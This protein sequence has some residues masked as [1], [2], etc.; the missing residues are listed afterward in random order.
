MLCTLSAAGGRRL[1]RLRPPTFCSFAQIASSFPIHIFS[2]PLS[3]NPLKKYSPPQLQSSWSRPPPAQQTSRPQ[4]Q[5]RRPTNTYS[6]LQSSLPVCASS[7]GN[8]S[9]PLP[10]IL[11]ALH[12]SL[13]ALHQSSTSPPQSY[14]Q[15][16]AQ[17]PTDGTSCYLPVTAMV[18]R[19][20]RFK[21]SRH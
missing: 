5:T 15:T 8:Y 20:T 17:P 6:L 21:D 2:F 7:F 10:P 13:P 4:D 3:Y 9:I 1:Q 19:K 12:Q 14:R 18:M 11:F 16:L